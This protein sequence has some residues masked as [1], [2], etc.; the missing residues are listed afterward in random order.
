MAEHARG[1][2]NDVEAYLSGQPEPQQTTLRKLR[3]TLI[4]LLPF[5]EEGLKYQMPAVILHGHAVA[6]YAGFTKH[7]SYFPCSG[8]VIGQVEDLPEWTRS[9]QGTL[10]FPVDRPLPAALVRRLLDARLAQFADVTDGKRYEY[11]PDGRLKAVGPM[12]GGQLHGKWQWFRRDGTLMRTGQ[13]RQGQ[14]VGL[15]QTWDREG[16]VVKSQRF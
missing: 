16:S 5:A 13:F 6:A 7:C 2:A 14:Q 8:D 10:Q 3:A 12:R 1:A 11:F 15:W 9:S 4:R